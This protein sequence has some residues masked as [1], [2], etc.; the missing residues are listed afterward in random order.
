MM[1][2]IEEFLDHDGALEQHRA[3]SIDSLL[4]FVGFCSLIADRELCKRTRS[5]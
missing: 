5:E 4:S 2:I 3:V 1:T